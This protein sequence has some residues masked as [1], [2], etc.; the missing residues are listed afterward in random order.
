MRARVGR[1]EMDLFAQ[2]SG[3]DVKLPQELIRA[4]QKEPGLRQIGPPFQQLGHGVGGFLGMAR[5]NLELSFGRDRF[6]E[7]GVDGDRFIE[8]DLGPGAIV[9]R[10]RGACQMQLDCG[11]FPFIGAVEF[12]QVF[13]RLLGFA[14]SDRDVRFEH[15]RL[16]VL[17][18]ARVNVSQQCESLLVI[19][20]G[21]GDLAEQAPSGDVIARLAGQ[22]GEKSFGVIGVVTRHQDLRIRDTR[23]RANRGKFSRSSEFLLGFHDLFSHQRMITERGVRE[24]GLWIGRERLLQIDLRLCSI[25]LAQGDRGRSYM[26]LDRVLVWKGSQFLCAFSNCSELRAVS[27]ARTSAS[28]LE[29]AVSNIAIASLFASP[30]TPTEA[31]ALASRKRISR[32]SGFCSR[33]LARKGKA[34]TGAPCS[35]QMKPSCRMALALLGSICRTAR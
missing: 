24:R 35:L 22:I 9:I 20:F 1:P 28:P 23:R 19:F 6:G 31:R 12:G 3:G 14:L 7:V 27:I 8:G 26:V 2:G 17:A 30:Q 5:S 13:D 25:V 29:G 32:S 34:G 10:H 16:H 21:E 4:G 33:V 18:I 15:A 11:H